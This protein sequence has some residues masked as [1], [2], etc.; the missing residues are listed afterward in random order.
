MN[1]KKSLGDADASP[2]IQASIHR[3]LVSPT[4]LAK[5]IGERIIW[6]D[7]NL[8]LQGWPLRLQSELQRIHDRPTWL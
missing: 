5:R 1:H 3:S 2:S 4:A 8:W 6:I 7:S